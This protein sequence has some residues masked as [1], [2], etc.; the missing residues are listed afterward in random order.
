M[1]KTLATLAILVA[2]STPTAQQLADLMGAA[3]VLGEVPMWENKYVRVHYTALEYPAAERQVAE[4]RPVVLYVR[5]VPESGVAVTRLLDAPQGARSPWRS[6]V[7]PRGIRIELLAPPQAPPA[8][9]ELGTDPPRGAVMEEHKG[10]RLVVAAFRPMDFG[11]GAGRFPSVTIFLSDGV[12]D[13]WSRGT[14]RR[15]GVRAGT[16]F[17]FEAATRLTIVSD[18]PVGAAVVQL[19]PR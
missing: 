7:M 5:V 1:R 4:A 15:M 9:G 3:K 16:A 11:V 10:Y 12:V 14:R 13:M 17:W 6:G 2:G 19:L 8:L 18:Y